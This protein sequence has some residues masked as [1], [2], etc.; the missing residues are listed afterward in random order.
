MKLFKHLPLAI[1]ILA[2]SAHAAENKLPW[3]LETFEKPLYSSK[4]SKG[5]FREVRTFDQ[6]SLCLNYEYAANLLD[7]QLIKAWE[8]SWKE[9]D[10]SAFSALLMEGANLPEWKSS[11]VKV[12]SQDYKKEALVASGGSAGSKFLKNYLENLGEVND[13]ELR[14]L[15]VDY[16][17]KNGNRLEASSA[18]SVKAFI[19]FD[20]RHGKS[21]ALKNDRGLF[22]ANLSLKDGRW[23]IQS[24]ELA[25][26]ES[27]S[28]SYKFFADGTAE[29]G[30]DKIPA[31]LRNEAIRRGGFALA[32]SD[33]NRDGFLDMV[34][35][36]EKE[37]VLLKG[38]KAK[39]FTPD[40]DQKNL[41]NEKSVKTAIFADLNNDGWDELILI[42]FVPDKTNSISVFQNKQGKF[43][44]SGMT[45]EKNAPDYAM[46]A[47]VGDFNLDGF[48]DLYVGFPGVKDFTTLEMQGTARS[49]PPG[50]SAPHGVYF[51][52]K[53]GSL[54]AAAKDSVFV[55]QG[56]KANNLAFPHAALA[57]DYDG[58]G[59][60]DVI[61]MDDRGGISPIFRNMGGGTFEQVSDRIGAANQGYG[62]GVAAADF[63]G[64]GNVDVAMTNVDFNAAVRFRNMCAQN[65]N[66]G[67]DQLLPLTA[68]FR[69]FKGLGNG[70]FAD[71]TKGSGLEWVG[72]GAGGVEFVDVD[73]DGWQDLVVANGLWSGTSRDNDLG[74]LFVRS[75]VAGL[76]ID[77]NDLD[78]TRSGFMEI[79]QSY[80]GSEKS[81]L[82]AGRLSMAGYQ[83]K[84]LFLNNHDGTFSEVGFLAGM[85]SVADGYVLAR[86]D[87][88]A[89]GKPDLVFRNADP[90]TNDH[91]FPA[92]QLFLNR[93]QNNNNRLKV[94]LEGSQGGS[95][96]N[97]IGA[98]VFVTL[99]GGKVMMQEMLSNNG[100]AQG[101]AA[102]FFGLGDKKRAEKVEV[103]WPSGKVDSLS[104]VQ[105]G[106]IK[107]REAGN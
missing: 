61:V 85:D 87:I 47:A 57:V 33:Y 99:A 7:T 2:P 66:G 31:Y 71:I 29:Y 63:D 100:S 62:M 68:G 105:A 16:G 104:Q 22:V 10:Y 34:V 42:H 103:R 40:L 20:I 12:P 84:R 15:N 19:A 93:M 86:A 28:S 26:G 94:E 39:K 48:L 107:V 44:D 91:M 55:N 38:S 97:A 36:T 43:I 96:R 46:P 30:L 73:G 78:T 54:L 51:N 49:Y 70:R 13:V 77:R 56:V 52:D 82:G 60:Q 83:H 21:G 32:V 37:M 65:L 64:D 4:K 50:K 72:E 106:K 76:A 80:N 24:I 101:E 59:K 79:L 53:N 6:D 18:K 95:N 8:K 69:L 14:L 88:D 98:K 89:D 92:V 74:S 11:S 75:V 3:L 58:D 90:G 27:V 41:L 81:P 5:P 67:R 17:L 35:G 25:S 1:I 102:L 9:K 45:P 23:K